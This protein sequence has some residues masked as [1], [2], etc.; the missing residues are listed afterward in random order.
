MAPR[1]GLVAVAGVCVAL[2]A[3]AAAQAATVAREDDALVVR[4]VPGAADDVAVTFVETDT[5]ARFY[6]T[7]V[8]GEGCAPEPGGPAPNGG[9]TPDVPAACDTTGIT[10]V[11]MLLGDGDDEVSVSGR[12]LPV[13][14][15][16]GPG[17]DRLSALDA[18]VVVASLGEGRD[19]VQDFQ[20]RT[21]A[22]AGGPGD[23]RIEAGKPGDAART[24]G[25]SSFD[26]G[27][28]NDLLRIVDVPA[29]LSGGPG[30]D[31]LRSAG[32]TADDVLC[33]TG[34]DTV[35]PDLADRVGD[36]CAPHLGGL[37]QRGSTLGQFSARS[38][39][40]L[41]RSGRLS[42]PGVATIRLRR[43]HPSGP[44]E[45]IARGTVRIRGRALRGSLRP[46]SSGLRRL[47]RLPRKQRLEVYVD[48]TVR[49][50]AGGADREIQ[51]FIAHVRR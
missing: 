46:T 41:L 29:R 38:R 45:T 35:R 50:R 44:Q 4:T 14:L 42:G 9:T 11:R 3:P 25:R 51:R 47:R 24:V 2:A 10:R 15:D 37:R 13:L 49:A 30:D 19:V 43:Y 7:V 12:R 33:G 23:D 27:P 22:I 48:V 32:T 34:A 40:V 5:R 18:G 31:D 21:A 16:L 36:A 8:P 17:D 1:P 20:A 28:G 26:G 39:R 6:G